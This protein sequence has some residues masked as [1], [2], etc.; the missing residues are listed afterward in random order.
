MAEPL[1]DELLVYSSHR[2][3]PSLFILPHRNAL[4]WVLKCTLWSCFNANCQ[5]LSL[6]KS[7]AMNSSLMG[8]L[9]DRNGEVMFEQK[10]EISYSEKYFSYLLICMCKW[11]YFIC[12]GA[13]GFIKLRFWNQSESWQ[14][15][16][17][18]FCS[19][20]LKSAIVFPGSF[21]VFYL[22]FGWKLFNP[23]LVHICRKQHW[24]KASPW[25][26][27]RV[28]PRDLN[29][30]V[31]GDDGFFPTSG[32]QFVSCWFS[33]STFSFENAPLKAIRTLKYRRKYTHFVW[34]C[35]GLN[36][37]FVACSHKYTYP[38]P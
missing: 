27:Q 18:I 11:A 26:G 12:L 20:F 38:K 7:V 32:S 3:C 15:N 36:D 10:P 8:K 23:N 24:I 33:I 34:S 1:H 37:Q 35:L 5:L 31:D 4:D 21:I 6:V 13:L 19:Q 25:I 16:T 29:M 30:P 28:N 9:V 14:G 22:A 2:L 17:S